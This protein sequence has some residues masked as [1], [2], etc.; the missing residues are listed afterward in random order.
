MRSESSSSITSAGVHA[1]GIRGRQLGDGQV[2]MKSIVS[3]PLTEDIAKHY[4]VRIKN[5][6]TGFKNIAAAIEQLGQSGER[7]RFL[8]GFEESLGYLYG[9]YTRD[10]DGIMAAQLICLAAAEARAQ[11]LTLVDRLQ[12]IYETYGY[13]AG[14]SFSVYYQD[15]KGR[16]KMQR[17]MERL[18]ADGLKP[19]GF[20]VKKELC[21]RKPPLYCADLADQARI[22]VRPSGTE[23]KL[24]TY[25]F[26]RGEAAQEAQ[27]AAAEIA[28]RMQNKWKDEGLYE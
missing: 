28:Q 20:R 5:V 21:Y 2:M 10:K 27:D 23:P 24:K 9:D 7:E 14:K 26:C 15:E 6:F 25:I 3:S 4:G 18:F 8:F 1:A 12:S 13:L 22:I 11:G 19:D 16:D 17:I